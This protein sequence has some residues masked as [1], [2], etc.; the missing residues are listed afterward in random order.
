MTAWRHGDAHEKVFAMVS[1]D[2]LAMRMVA[3]E[4]RTG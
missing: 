2:M 3:R 1:E 4:N